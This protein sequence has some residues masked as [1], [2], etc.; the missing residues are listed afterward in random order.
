MLKKEAFYIH[1]AVSL[2]VSDDATVEFINS[3]QW[4]PNAPDLHSSD[5]RVRNE[6][7]SQ[8]TACLTD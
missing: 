7:S 4:P 3:T 6:Q 1:T 2:K 5:C 8:V